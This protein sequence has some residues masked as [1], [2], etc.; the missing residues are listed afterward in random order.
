[1]R[2]RR[3]GLK[4]EDRKALRCVRCVVHSDGCLRRRHSCRGECWTYYILHQ[5]T[6]STWKGFVRTVLERHSREQNYCSSDRADG[7]SADPLLE[8]IP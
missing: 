3:R 1:M 7:G 5:R 4:A 8:C 2:G 6:R